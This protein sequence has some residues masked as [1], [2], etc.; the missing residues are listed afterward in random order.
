MGVD[1]EHKALI[2][3][4]A[5]VVLGVGVRLTRDR[6]A[7]DSMIGAAPANAEV[8]RPLTASPNGRAGRAGGSS[9]QQPGKRSKGRGTKAAQPA[10]NTNIPPLPAAPAP[11]MG[12]L[13][14]AGYIGPRLDLDGAT[15]AQIESLP[16]IGP[17]LASRIVADRAAHGPF[18]SK[19]GLNR[20]RGIGPVLLRRLDT[21]VTF[22]GR[23]TP[24]PDSGAAS[25]KANGLTSKTPRAKSS[26]VD[27]KKKAKN[28]RFS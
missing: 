25:A 24:L 26:S 7:V 6:G 28:P 10:Q 3:V 13:D 19:E 5:V 18:I 15:L 23:L 4:A 27:T 12:G 21:L 20:V 14:R 1:S 9:A 16:G 17:T 2:I 11:V 8:R 22:S